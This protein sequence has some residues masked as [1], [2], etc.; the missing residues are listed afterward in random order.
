VATSFDATARINLDIRAFAQGAQ[1]ITKSGGQMEKVFQ[2]LNT[3][4]SKVAHVDADL[5]A[6]IRTTT[7]AYNAAISVVKNLAQA[8]AQL[9]KSEQSQANVTKT[10]VGTFAQLKSALAEVNGLSAKE[11]QRIAR[12]VAIYERLAKVVATLANAQKSTSQITQN[13]IAAQQK[14]EQ[15]KRKAA[16]TAQR[17]A[18]EEQKL[19]IQRE[20]LAQAAQR[21]AQQEQALANARARAAQATQAA[22]QSTVSFSGSTF[23]LRNT[24]GELEQS[25]QS[26]FNVLIRVP[27]ALAS[28]AISQ[29]TAF[30]QV[31]RV[32]GV[33]EA[34]SVGLLERFQQ[35]AQQAPISFEEVARIGQL[36]AAIGISEQNLGD[37][38]DTIVKF[39][40][41]TG[42]AS[43]EATILLG[44]IAQMQNVPISQIEQLGSAILALG[45]ASAATDQEILRVN[46]SIA[47]VS[48]L[49]GL[50]AQQTA[51]LSAALATL[52]V[53]P[54]LSRG[55]L[56]RVF[57]DLT[58]AVSDGG[59]EL[60]KLAKIM[61]MTDKEVTN[62]FNNPATRGDFLLAFI[63]GLSRAAGAGGEVQGVLRE[64]GVNAVRDIDVFSRLAN[65]VDIVKESFDRANLEFARGTELQRQSKGIYETTSA[66]LQ[67]LS[68]AF[69][70][71]LATLGG[72][73][74]K[75]IG[76]VA[77]GLSEVIGF[78]AHLGPVVPIVGT[79]TGV[80]IAAGAA[81]TLYQVALS[82]TIQSLI[83]TR[84]LQERLKVTTLSARVAIDIYRNGFQ[85][86]TTA[87]A[88]TAN[89]QRQLTTST[90]VLTA[91]LIASSR[92]IQGYSLTASQSAS[93]LNAMGLASANAARGQDA[94]F[95]STLLTQNAMRQL[96]AQSTASALAMASVSNVNKNLALTQTQMANSS[97]VFAGQTAIAATAVNGLN[98]STL[99]AVPATNQMSGSIRNAA[100]A[101][102]QMGAGM[103]AAAV[104]S[105]TAA[106]AFTRATTG[107]TAAG[108]AARIAAFAFGPW[109]LA[110]A[111]AGI[112]LG[113]LIGRM[114][115]FRSESERI[116]DAAFEA[117]GGTKALANA[118]EADT[119]AAVKAAGGLKGYNQAIKDGS[120]SALGAI[121]VYRTITTTKSDLADADVRSAEA[122]RSEARERLR[123]IEATKGSKAA[124]EEQAK[125]HG[126]GAQAAARY[127]REILKAEGVID[128]TTAALGRNTAALGE[129][130]KQWL[131]DTAQA[132]IETSKLADGSEISQRALEQLGETGVDVGDLLE[133][134]LS[135]PDK[136]LSQL[137]AAIN[138]VSKTADNFDPG[139]G[140]SEFG[141]SINDQAS[142]AKR[143][144]GFLEALRTT[145][146][147]E[148]S[149]AT[150]LSITKGLL[151]DALDETGES[152]SS[153]SGKIKLT[154]DA[155]EDL[156][157]SG[158]DAQQVID[159]L[160]QSF[161]KFGTPLDA[162]KA[163]AESA[164]GKAENAID[165]FSL[166]TKD[167]LNAYIKELEKI[168]K[169]QR[170][171]SA[172]LIKIS[173]TLGP[174]V[175]E[176]FRK[177]GPEAAPAVAELANLSAKELEK[178][179]PRLAEIGGDATS[180]LAAAI[181]QNSGKVE[182]ATLQARTV[183]ADLFENAIDSAKTADD[184]A[185]V[186][187]Q[188]QGLLTKLSN[189]KGVKIDITADQAKALKSLKDLETFIDLVGKKKIKPEVAIDIIKA[190]GDLTKL[191]GILKAAEANGS[192]NAKGKATLEGLIFAGQLTQ[193][194]TMVKD[195][196]LR[197]QLDAEG[198]ATLTDEAYRQKVLGLTEFLASAEGQGL[199][200]PKGKAQLDDAAYRA[201]MEA[202][203]SLILGEEAAG[204]FDVDG[205]GDLDDD[206]FKALLEALK[207][208]VAK[209]NKGQLD[210][211]GTV[212]LAGVG[213]FKNQLGGIVQAAYR[214][215][216]QISQALTRSAT[217]S[218]GYYYYQKNS[219]PSGG[220]G[221]SYNTAIA[222]ANGGWINGPGGPK[223]DAIPAW[224]SNGEFVVNAA[225]ASRF[226]AL[227][228]VI[229]RAGGRGFSGV[230]R[231]LLD[232]GI[233]GGSK[234]VNVTQLKGTGGGFGS[235]AMATQ[236]PPESVSV[237]SSRLAM[238][239]GGPTNVF[240]INNQYPQAEPTSTTINRSLA[241]AATISG[242]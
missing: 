22:H 5:A 109:G 140:V 49:F 239:Q 122:A 11:Y 82:K 212:T 12:T 136:A 105:A 108:T 69:K 15:S 38:T 138:E 59:T 90:D 186:S 126:T 222:A 13:A 41:T 242:V 29:E 161:E 209:A 157:T 189:L 198:K 181:I 115:D 199:L 192:L 154:R 54:E 17:L 104:S 135:Q 203:A 143:L 89:S 195:F 99:K 197:K 84:E 213:N 39:S 129:N 175:A 170:D 79:L 63:Q 160:A 205:S 14:D 67:N 96:S 6:K 166:K 3:V 132:A 227:L 20:K 77:S 111:T 64:L 68:D 172:N 147:A 1:A 232:A 179:G 80:V 91:S 146:A 100:L 193:L 76:S 139:G 164:F 233:T 191:T 223:A 211:K 92:A 101:G 98:T 87:Q 102:A 78:F 56:T 184:F 34:A 71:L 238:P 125:G 188:Y 21:I 176:Q 169:A 95:A 51:G 36:G 124:L 8:S 50:T 40:L 236:V 107:I 190:Q 131:L 48:N 155:L 19:A 73:L 224:L 234:P 221:G 137:D 106:G 168:S 149:A 229:N 237:F 230:A 4:M 25:F 18:L 159:S 142:S 65:N 30:A 217:V 130:T 43:E 216:S 201:Q 116:A 81:W 241:Y 240:N 28:A 112:L 202:L 235:G 156:E 24:V 97:R 42:V 231:N 70:T 47:T 72:P 206:E 165:K 141:K 55:A 127:L 215:G 53:R 123:A 57:N 46:A 114:F 103:N 194:S 162:F 178:L 182:N 214:S 128:Q 150:K 44:R 88:A 2:N 171:W 9:A 58:L 151:A 31:A 218:V 153:S 228:E 204:K 118:I 207:A 177:L 119:D 183:I 86:A 225:A 33:A 208:A 187:N 32:V 74:A 219:P 110:I 52:Q 94:L 167:G 7:S 61:G 120:Q 37:F 185:D 85:G 133:L 148:D 117:T 62:L 93:G 158:E 180:N 27:T 163:A 26:L 66:E 173:T 144:Q 16:E 200:N 121:G 83:A 196:Q 174:E 75:A 60:Q 134:S 226:G 145:I 45:T 10:L 220:G 210:P 35:I 152:A 113:P 23:A